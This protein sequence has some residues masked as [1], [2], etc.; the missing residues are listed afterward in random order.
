MTPEG[1][2]RIGSVEDA[3]DP[4]LS[5]YHALRDRQWRRRAPI[6]LV[7]SA[8]LVRR[9]V[10]ES[11]F[12]VRSL[13]VTPAALEGLRDTLERAGAGMEVHV[14][15]P[16]LLRQVL[17]FE[18]HR[19]CLAVAERGPALEAQ[20]LIEPPGARTVLVLEAVRDPDNVGALFRDA[21]SFGAEA[22]LLTPGAGDPLYPKAIRA[23][24]GASLT[25]PF[26]R[27]PDWPAQ[28]ARLREAGYALLA[29]APAGE[30]GLVDLGRTRRVPSRAALLVGGEGE[31]LGE[32]ARA[33]A[34]LSVRIAM[35]PGADSLNV[36]VAAGIALHWLTEASRADP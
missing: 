23:S 35:A 13:L 34:D 18:F 5:D 8:L 15:A 9:L 3:Q 26:A 10:T 22:V 16:A 11:P 2:P 4:C 33:A 30:T 19:G 36:A 7:E 32:A 14:G 27:L 6:F 20:R 31:G 28:V 17:G 29:L 24:A 1:G 12:R 25:V 21:R